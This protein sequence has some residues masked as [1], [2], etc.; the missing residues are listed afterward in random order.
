MKQKRKQI[1]KNNQT[2][3]HFILIRFAVFENTC[4][5]YRCIHQCKVFDLEGTS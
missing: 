4:T 2:S 3:I 1:L 5:I